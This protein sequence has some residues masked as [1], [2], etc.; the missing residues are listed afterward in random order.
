[1]K[2]LYD[3]QQT[4]KS[5]LTKSL[6]SQT[7]AT[8]SSASTGTGKTVVSAKIAREHPG[9]VGVICTKSSIEHWRR[10][11]AEEGVS[12]VFILNYES[13]RRGRT[14]I[15]AKAGKKL[16]RWQLPPGT[17]VIVDEVHKCKGAYTQNAQL[18]ISLKQQGYPVLAL[19]AT[20]SKDPSEMR[21]LG[22]LLGLHKLNDPTNSWDLWIRELGC[23]LDDY[24]R[25]VTNSLNVQRTLHEEIYKQRKCAHRITVADMPE[26][27]RNNT[28]MQEFVDLGPEV[29]KAFEIEGLSTIIVDSLVEGIHTRMEKDRENILTEL[30]RARQLAE[31]RK[32]PI[33]EERIRDS[34]DEGL[35][36]IIFCEFTE[37]VRALNT[38]FPE[39]GVIIGGQPGRDRQEVIDRFAADEIRIVVATVGSGGESINLHDQRG[40]FPRISLISPPWSV[41]VYEQCLGRAYRA[42]AKTDTIQKLI[43]AADTIEERVAAVLEKKRKELTMLH[44]GR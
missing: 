28:V 9:P 44:E 13:L 30:L 16:F 38:V 2:T 14:G 20:A 19:S 12:P 39:A 3:A 15:L 25:W 21:A 23:T 27:F 5:V 36:P 8:L 11:L 24:G 34:L 7:G 1:M 10:E 35:S 43:I 37:T 41:V 32:L 22:F 6:Y 31:A 42:A 26:A 4:H 33:F 29:R 17:L 40:E 18:L